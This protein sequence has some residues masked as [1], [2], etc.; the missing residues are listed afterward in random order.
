MMPIT[1][2]KIVP[3]LFAAALLCAAVPARSAASLDEATANRIT[4]ILTATPL[5]DGHNDFAEALHEKFGNKLWTTD[6]TGTPDSPVTKLQT[7]IRRLRQGQLGGQFWSVWVP[8]SITGAEAVRATLVQIDTV[9]GLVDRYP[10][11]FALAATADDIVRIHKS[12]RIASMMG[13]EGGHQIGESIAALRQFYAL[14]ARYMTLTHTTNNALA[15]SAT[16]NPVHKGLTPFGRAVVTEM[17]RLGMLVDI[18]HVSPEVMRQAIDL[19]RAPVM[20]SHSSARAVTDHPRNVPDD[21][22]QMIALHDG[23]VMVNFVPDYVSNDMN[24][25]VADKAAETARYSSPP[26][27]GL[28]IGQPERAAAA[29]ATWEKAHPRPLV[30]VK[31]VADHIE[32][33]V[34]VAGIDHVGIGSDFDGIDMVPDGLAS[35]ADYPNLFA[36]LIHRG[37]TDAMLAKLA[38][39][40]LLR[41]MRKAEAVSASMKA[42]MPA[43]PSIADLGP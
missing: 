16:D 4:R 18:S 1:V 26:Y 19:S 34:K 29:L 3:V 22:L 38:G 17:N 31:D 42:M 5:I 20:F 24:Q 25:W 2:P 6:L 15:D 14:G 13:V 33:I 10:E 40:N 37:W 23:V 35:V 30:T 12:G 39:N 43:N 7:D 41:V 36:E 9:R 28:Y 11:T 32:H 21:V 8:V 27:N